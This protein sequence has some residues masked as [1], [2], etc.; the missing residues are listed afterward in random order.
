MQSIIVA[1]EAAAV[2]GAATFLVS[3][4]GKP[5]TPASIGMALATRPRLLLLDEPTASLDPGNAELVMET[6][7][8]INRERGITV[9]ANL[10]NVALARAHSDRIIALTDGRVVFDGEV[11]ALE[12]LTMHL[13]VNTRALLKGGNDGG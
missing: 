1:I 5:F 3:G 7:R 2:V 6:L 12:H 8:R 10:H 13:A 9:I 11:G 4:H